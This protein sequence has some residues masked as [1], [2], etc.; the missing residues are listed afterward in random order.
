VAHHAVT[1]GGTSRRGSPPVVLKPRW[2]SGRAVHLSPVL[3]AMSCVSL[4]PV[5]LL[6]RAAFTGEASVSLGA[7]L[8][9]AKDEERA[10]PVERERRPLPSSWRSGRHVARALG[11]RGE[12]P[13]PRDTLPRSRDLTRTPLG[14]WLTIDSSPRDLENGR[15][16]AA[17]PVAGAGW[18][19]TRARL[20]GGARAPPE[21]A[22][23][24]AEIVCDARRRL[25]GPWLGL[26]HPARRE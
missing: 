6:E 25:V 19:P 7:H 13:S 23:V 12:W 15:V 2:S 22:F 1:S 18:P 21:R 26:A 16:G 14:A 10:R 4:V 8:T 9:A 24:R 20:G 11:R 5:A 17:C 3:A